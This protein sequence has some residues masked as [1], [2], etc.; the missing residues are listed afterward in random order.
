MKKQEDKILEGL[1]KEQKQAVT[2]KQGPF[3]VIAGAG[4][5]K[6][7]V[8]TRRLAWLILN[9]KINPEDILAVTFT[10]KA[11]Q[12]MEERVDRLLPYG[13][14]DLWISTFHSFCERV[15]RE[16][17]LEIGLSPDFKILDESAQALFVFNNFSRFNL[18]YYR[19]LGNPYRFIHSL[20]K[21][22]SR[23]KDELVSPED[24]FNYIKELELNKD[25]SLS[26]SEISE[27]IK[28]QK[29][30]AQAYSIYQKLLLEQGMLDFGD[31][32]IYTLKLFKQRPS[33]LKKY[34]DKFKYILIDEFQDTN[35][36][37]YELMKALAAP[38]NNLCVVFDDDQAIFLWRGASYNNVFQ[39]RKDYPQAQAI[40]LLKNYRS[41]QNILDL[42]YNFIQ[43]NNPDR[44]EAQIS[45]IENNVFKKKISKKLQA[46]RQG[47]GVIKVFSGQ[48]H[49]QEVEFVIK[50]IIELKNKNPELSWNDFAILAR[51]NKSLEPFSKLLEYSAVPYQFLA[52]SG[53]F[54]KPLILDILA[55]LKLLDNY[56][57]S[58]SVYRILVSPL[59]L[60]SLTNKDLSLLTQESRKNSWSLFETL[61]KANLIKGLSQ[62]ALLSINKLLSL[63]E[64]HSLLAR[65][66]PVSKIVYRFLNESGYLKILKDQ[67][68]KDNPQAWESISFL[69]QFFRRIER[70]EKENPDCLVRNFIE[71]IDRLIQ[72]GDFGAISPELEGPESVKLLTVHAAKGL[73]F[74]YVF[75]V[76][77]TNRQFPTSQ[78][79]DLIP[80]PDSLIKGIVPSGDTHLQEERR[81][82]YVGLTRAKDGLFLCWAK[83]YGTKTLR[84]PSRF[85]YELDL[86]EKQEKEK[87]D[88][89]KIKLHIPITAKAKVKKQVKEKPL[90]K[91]FSF[92]QIIDFTT[93]PLQYKYRYLLNIPTAGRPTYSFGKSIHN[94]LAEFSKL[95]L[96]AKQE[97]DSLFSLKNAQKKKKIIPSLEELLRLYEKNWIEEWYESKEQKQ[98][99][100]EKGKEILV[101]FYEN[102]K[103]KMPEIV[104]VEQEFTF[105]LDKYI[106]KGRIDRIDKID[107]GFK[108]IDYKTGKKKDIKSSSVKDQLVI[109]CLA[110]NSSPFS[111]LQ[112]VKKLSAY[113]LESGEEL[114]FEVSEKEI[115]SIKTRIVQVIEELMKSDFPPQPG[116]HCQFC[117]YYHICQFREKSFR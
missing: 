77:L 84:K 73:E 12:E 42:A 26:S 67:A 110:L 65:S 5:G 32:L 109:Y 103:K 11:A 19:P 18:D 13:Y 28:R 14:L 38:R 17:A 10:E 79:P 90:P 88:K 46:V 29:E 31:L 58:S 91:S 34:Q 60:N 25:S 107:Q 99:Y 92:T 108:V 114:E 96:K 89:E 82:F 48:T 87:I 8:I 37:Q 40:T 105:P 101:N 70:F 115:N 113:Y 4:T 7:T 112:P 15:L 21:H 97:Q 83:D 61:Q 57:E 55:Y 94:T 52:H 106:F 104:A 62:K 100:K 78:R 6:T 64:K 111:E 41:Y 116:Y 24:Y 16:N 3:L 33:I 74:K 2:Y 45:K 66:E 68:D 63:I 53:L 102:F 85:L 23:A 20:I 1:N 43:K 50:K 49:E 72:L 98:E 27:E 81:L 86:L 76:D 93:C 54:S 80:F 56:H 44:L 75:I 9:Q 39:F 22:F 36:A 69:N 117:D 30:I 35:F 95:Y 51:T 59:F 71:S 47:K